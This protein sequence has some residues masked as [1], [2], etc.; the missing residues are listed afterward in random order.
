MGQMGS[1]TACVCMSA[2]WEQ[3]DKHEYVVS[4]L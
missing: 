1:T 3:K 2:M 4:L